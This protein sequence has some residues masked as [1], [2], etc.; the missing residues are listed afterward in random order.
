V[1]VPTANAVQKLARSFSEEA[2]RTL[3]AIMR[4]AEIHGNVRIKACEAI[5]NRGLGLP[6]V[7]LDITVQKLLA[8]RLIELN[9]DELRQVE[10]ALG[11]PAIDV[12]PETETAS[13]SDS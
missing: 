13:A 3:V 4:N 5:M 9:V 6:T 2:L 1:Q 8:R 7:A 12:T 11:E 10:A